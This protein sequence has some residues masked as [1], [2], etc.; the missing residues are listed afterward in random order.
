[1][2]CIWPLYITLLAPMAWA[3]LADD[4]FS[5]TLEELLLVEVSG[6]TLT[7]ES[8]STVPAAVTVFTH[9]EIKDMG[10]D[11]LDE[12]ANFVPGFQSYRTAQSPLQNPISSRGRLI[13][14]E[15]SELL[16]LIDGQRADGPRSNGITVPL[17]KISLDYIE[18]VEFIRGPGSAIYGSN[19]M[20]GVINITTRSNDNVM[21][22]SSG[23]FKRKKV[24][25][26]FARQ[27]K[28]VEVD[29]FVQLDRDDGEDYSLVDTFSTNPLNTDDPRE[30]NDFIL[31]LNRGDTHLNIQH[32]L[33]ESEN[34]YELAG[35][36]NGFNERNASLSAISLKQ[37]FN[38]LGVESWLQTDY[39]ETR[40][41]LAGQLTPAGFLTGFSDPSSADALFALAVFND[42]SEGHVQWHNN[43]T[44]ELNRHSQSQLQFGFEYRY[45]DAPQTKTKNN[46]DLGEL[47]NGVSPVTYYGTFLPTTEV[48]EASTRNHLAQYLQ[49]QHNIFENTQLILGLRH[50]DVNSLGSKISPRF[51][52]VQALNEQHVLKLLYGEAFRVPSESELNLK[53]NPVLLGNPNLKAESVKTLDIIWMGSWSNRAYT[54]GYFENHF[55]DAIIQ[56]PSELGIPRFENVDQDP[57]KGFEFEISQQLAD[58][59]LLK[60]TYTY[61]TDNADVN[62]REANKLGSL[63]MNFSYLKWNANL[64]A[65]WQDK[66]EL[67]AI[68]AQS[69][70]LELASRWLV[71][72]KLSYRHNSHLK[73]FLQVKNLANT[74]YNSPTLGAALDQ[75]VP[76]RGRE[77]L[78]GVGWS[79]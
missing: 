61:I 29:V 66:R 71:Y 58:S 60:G 46:F 65:S 67:P 38:W 34:F 68:D 27:L 39:R 1:M 48:Q 36:S 11:Y 24:T 17:S 54:L 43:V 2:K 8:L 44:L 12:L 49:F 16:V 40:V 69:Q 20:M 45:V 70:R 19:A 53:N 26:Q 6:S 47:A 51:G 5:M 75:G 78:M 21:S 10:L 56:T 9:Q 7:L 32:H 28:E 76:N 41:K 23:S 73:S 30:V 52:M 33:Y 14:I 50:D 42:Y 77:I 74:E 72:G 62:F 25:L 3:Q 37:A 55:S 79:F 18:K 31:K 4:Y 57:S 64:L 13:S 63:S 35:L 15:A 22:L 59:L